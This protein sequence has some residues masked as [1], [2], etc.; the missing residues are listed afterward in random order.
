LARRKME[1]ER[2]LRQLLARQGQMFQPAGVRAVETDPRVLLDEM[3]AELTRVVSNLT[4]LHE[5]RSA[6]SDQFREYL[7]AARSSMDRVAQLVEECDRYS[8]PVH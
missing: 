7:A 6:A 8:D 5:N 1:L 2:A 3:D 4:R